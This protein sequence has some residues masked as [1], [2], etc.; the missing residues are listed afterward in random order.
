MQKKKG[1]IEKINDR[2]IYQ[3]FYDPIERRIGKLKALGV[4][5]KDACSDGL[6]ICEEYF[7]VINKIREDLK[8]RIIAE[9]AKEGIKFTGD[10][11]PEQ[12]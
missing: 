11:Y 5:E 3:Y 2:V 8:N 7:N 12:F 4:S 9:E 6:L 1:I 10:I